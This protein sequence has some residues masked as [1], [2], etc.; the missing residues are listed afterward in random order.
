MM[1][2]HQSLWIRAKYNSNCAECESDIEEGERIVFDTETRKIYCNDCGEEVA[3]ED[4]AQ[5]SYI[6]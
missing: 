6:K 1:P 3:G 5:R 2:D 4:P